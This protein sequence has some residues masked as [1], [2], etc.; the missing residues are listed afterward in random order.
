M[1]PQL[2]ARASLKMSAEREELSVVH[3]LVILAGATPALSSRSL[4]SWSLDS[5]SR[6]ILMSHF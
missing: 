2:P 4:Y 6:V 3:L 5:A 1:V